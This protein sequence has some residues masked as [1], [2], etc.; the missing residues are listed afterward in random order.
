MAIDSICFLKT[1]SLR[2]FSAMH[3]TNQSLADSDYSAGVPETDQQLNALGAEGWEL[4]AVTIE[5]R[6]QYSGT[7]F[8]RTYHLKRIR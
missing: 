3:R 6:P 1:A 4:I 7:R 8:V 2:S 5:E